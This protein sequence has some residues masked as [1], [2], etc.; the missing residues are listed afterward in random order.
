MKKVHDK[1]VNNDMTE[2]QSLTRVGRNELKSEGEVSD[3]GHCEIRPCSVP[4]HVLGFDLSR[5]K[6]Y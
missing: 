2:I 4:S 3:D 5:K 6:E 1:R